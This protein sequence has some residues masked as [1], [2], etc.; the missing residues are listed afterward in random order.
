MKAAVRQVSQNKAA[1]DGDGRRRSARRCVRCPKK[2]TRWRRFRV[3]PKKLSSP[4]NILK[5]YPFQR[6]LCL[7]SLH[8]LVFLSISLAAP[9]ESWWKNYKADKPPEYLTPPWASAPGMEDVKL[10]EAPKVR[11]LAAPF[12]A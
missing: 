10:P 9:E 2:K 3:R 11:F 7:V 12:L 8:M 4:D 5:M 6:R 1:R